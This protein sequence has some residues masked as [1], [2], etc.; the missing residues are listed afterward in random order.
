VAVGRLVLG[1]VR[2]GVVRF[3]VVLDAAALRAL[4]RAGRLP[5][6]VRISVLS[7]HGVGVFATRKVTLVRSPARR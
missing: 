7:V 6:M 3:S 2:V 1:L 4:S 5:L